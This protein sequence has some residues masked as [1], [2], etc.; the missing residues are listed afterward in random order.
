MFQT[1]RAIRFPKGSGK[2]FKQPFFAQMPNA[3][4]G[5]VLGDRLTQTLPCWHSTHKSTEKGGMRIF[6]LKKIAR[7]SHVLYHRT[8]DRKTDL[9]TATL[10]YSAGTHLAF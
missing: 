8:F 10:L 2:N 6:L 9:N 7:Q 5:M 3:T 1:L 4:L